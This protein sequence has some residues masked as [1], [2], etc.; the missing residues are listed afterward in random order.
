MSPEDRAK[1]SKFEPAHKELA[2]GR[3]RRIAT[4]KA[5][6]ITRPVRQAGQRI[7]QCGGNLPAQRVERGKR[8]SGPRS[9]SIP[10]HSGKGRA[11]K[12]ERSP[13]IRLGAFAIEDRFR[14]QQGKHICIF[15]PVTQRCLGAGQHWP[16][17]LRIQIS[18]FGRVHPKGV[19]ANVIK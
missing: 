2:I 3:I 15:R 14:R 8:I 11:R 10:L 17:L 16:V 5:A 7:I 18:R 4:D 12:Y 9:R 6:Y 13:V 19:H 1:R